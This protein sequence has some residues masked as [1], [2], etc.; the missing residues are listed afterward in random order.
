MLT[1]VFISSHIF[2]FCLG[3]FALF[4]FLFVFICFLVG[5]FFR[6]FKK[7]VDHLELLFSKLPNHLIR[8]NSRI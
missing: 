8:T 2:D 6:I 4:C 7:S 5:F 3:F 1:S